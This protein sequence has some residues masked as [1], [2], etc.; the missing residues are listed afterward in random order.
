MIEYRVADGTAARAID[1]DL[2]ALR[3]S[4]G[5]LSH[6]IRIFPLRVRKFHLV[7]IEI[8]LAPDIT[9]ADLFSISGF[10]ARLLPYAARIQP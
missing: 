3:Q 10:S 2:L 4:L 9:V 5:P 8:A 1:H 6:L 7:S